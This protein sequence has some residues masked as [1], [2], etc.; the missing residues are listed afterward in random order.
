MNVWVAV[1]VVTGADQDLQR[2][3]AVA[4][5]EAGNPELAVRV[6]DLIHEDGRVAVVMEKY[7]EGDVRTAAARVPGDVPE[8]FLAACRPLERYH[9]QQFV[10]LN[11]RPSK[12]LVGHEGHVVFA[13]PLLRDTLIPTT[14]GTEVPPCRHPS[15]PPEMHEGGTVDER[16]DVYGL[17]CTLEDALADLTPALTG[18]GARVRAELTR[19][20]APE[21]NARHRNVGELKEALR[22]AFE[23]DAQHH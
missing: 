7:A 1:R 20:R 21:P 19:A 12:L 11:L 4:R 8:L 18:A 9:A 14:K 23:A 6:T 3:I 10:H 22:L 5:I 13:D 17:A 2:A 16:A 15:A